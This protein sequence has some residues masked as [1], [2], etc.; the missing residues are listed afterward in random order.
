LA[1]HQSDRALGGIGR[2]LD[3]EGVHARPGHDLDGVLPTSAGRGYRGEERPAGY[4]RC[5]RQP[6]NAVQ[7]LAERQC[8]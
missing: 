7:R 1:V 8:V 2:K 6:R 5:R 3:R 4:Q